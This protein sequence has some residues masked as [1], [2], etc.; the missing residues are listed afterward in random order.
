M[1]E[2]KLNVGDMTEDAVQASVEDA[3][4]SD[5]VFHSPSRIGGKEVTDVL[6]L[7]DDLG[8]VVE[9]KAQAI[10][11]SS[12]LSWAKKN[13]KK[14]VNQTTGAI[15]ALRDGRVPHVENERR[16]QVPFSIEEFKFLY[17]LVIL[18]HESESYDPYDVFPDIK[19]LKHPVHVL[20]FRD[21][22]NLSKYLDTA[23]D[24]ISY[25]ESRS[26]VLIPTLKPRVHEE[27]NAF[28]YYLEHL[29][30]I[31]VAEARAHGD[32]SFRSEDAEPYAQQMRDMISQA[33]PDIKAGRVIDHMIE[34][35]HVQDPQLRTLDLG[36][37]AISWADKTT[38]A[39]IATALGMIPRVRR[40]SLGRKYIQ[41][42]E[43]AAETQN[44]ESFW[45]FSQKRSQFM[46]FVSSPLPRSDREK[47]AKDL[48]TMTVLGKNYF[49]ANKALGVA[50]GQAGEMGSSYDFVLLESPSQKP[51]DE[52]LRLG[53][54]FF[55][56]NNN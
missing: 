45:T 1:M 36:G 39:K 14:A 23:A 47:R 26:I 22:W 13:L 32:S 3:F 2:F 34:K 31:K 40:I 16:G 21:F 18:H 29:E 4:S 15:R 50:T 12:S 28:R 49:R 10:G 20:S 9:S 56:K 42:A 54:E 51:D 17:A 5:F 33:H 30:E 52:T 37:K 6:V 41:I 7:F 48:L 38:Y 27:S 8:I 24:L 55:G 19:R 43:K 25:I 53:Q 46:F 11:G 35:I 44:D